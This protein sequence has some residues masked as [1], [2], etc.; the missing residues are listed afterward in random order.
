M[1]TNNKPQK[2][3]HDYYK[4]EARA[5]RR[6]YEAQSKEAAHT[7]GPWKAVAV[8]DPV[9]FKRQTRN[10]RMEVFDANGQRVVRLGGTFD[11]YN[12]AR[13]IAAAPELL[14]A[15]KSVCTAYRCEC[16]DEEPRPHCPMCLGRAAIAK[17]EGGK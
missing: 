4:R 13:L 3:D 1:P 11:D 9:P 12:N 7:P 15:L 2:K 17:A 5:N 10:H 8:S 14:E 16:L 6:A